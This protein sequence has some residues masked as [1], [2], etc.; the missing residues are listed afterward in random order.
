MTNRQGVTRTVLGCGFALL[1]ACSSDKHGAFVTPDGDGG[2]SATGNRAGAGGSSGRSGGGRG[3]S[4]GRGGAGGSSVAGGAAGEG[5]EEANAAA[6]LVTITRPLQVTNPTKGPVVLDQVHVV[7]EAKASNVKN[8]SF[9]ASSV[10]IEVFDADG[11]PVQK[12]AGTRDASDVNLFLADFVLTRTQVPNGAISFKCTANDLSTP[13]NVGSDTVSTFIDH[14]PLITAMSPSLPTAQNVLDYRAL[15]TAV[16]FRFTV[17]PDPLA[18]TDTQAT[19]STVT[20]TVNNE[21]I[22]LSTAESTTTKGTYQLDLRLDD[23]EKFKITPNGA[24]SVDIT[25]T[26]KRAPLPTE[27][28]DPVKAQ[29]AYNFGVDGAG[30]QVTIVSPSPLIPTVVGVAVKLQF[31]VK[32]VESGV[33]PSTVNVSLN[34]APAKYYDAGNSAWGRTGDNYTFNIP[35]TNAVSGSK[36]Q[37]TV[38]VQASDNSK[39]KSLAA[40]AQYWLDTSA[41][42]VDLDP[43]NVQEIRSNGTGQDCSDPFDVLGSASPSEGATVPAANIFRALVWDL[44]NSTD[45]QKIFH[46]ARVDPATVRLY[47]QDD[48]TQPLLIDTNNDGVCDALAIE[49]TQGVVHAPVPIELHPLDAAGSAVYATT[50]PDINGVCS[51]VTSNGSAIQNLCTAQHVSDMSR[52]IDHALGDAKEDVIYAVTSS[53]DLECTGK[54]VDI[55]GAVPNGWVCLAAEAQDN[56]GNH[57]ISAPIRV[58]LYAKAHDVPACANSSVAKP[59]CVSNCTPPVHFSNSYVVRLN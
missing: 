44:T 35:D 7:C 38:V 32:D 21:P 47:A 23:A 34:G 14:G 33:D 46:H 17:V 19:V 15:T 42:I 4:A 55:S 49:G 24:V 36:I 30:P 10:S 8:A 37:L 53:S 54:A 39:N 18:T 57:G 51:H 59:S 48:A 25:A 3:G 50:S 52:V 16:P 1:A 43:P 45:G 40:T 20:L 41:P 26:N 6:P 28:P 27:H 29:L 11:R 31:S 9:A 58:C 22:D 56:V 2:A 12:L 13:A 5:G